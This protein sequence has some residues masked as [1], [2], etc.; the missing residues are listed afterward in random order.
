[1]NRNIALAV[2]GVLSALAV[3]GFMYARKPKP[4]PVY[5]SRDIC[6]QLWCAYKRFPKG[7]HGLIAYETLTNAAYGNKQLTADE[8]VEIKETIESGI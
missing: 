3:G 7:V 4:E 5:V 2:G 6:T 8:L 1:M